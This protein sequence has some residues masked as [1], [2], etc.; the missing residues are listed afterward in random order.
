MQE[1]I[2]TS[3]TVIINFTYSH[4]AL[5][6]HAASTTPILKAEYKHSLPAD[7]VRKFKWTGAHENS[8]NQVKG[9]VSKDT[10][11]RFPDHSVPLKYILMPETTKLEEM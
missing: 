9:L 2:S 7:I 6:V 8:F 11:L 3:K 4:S 10:L 5:A 1:N